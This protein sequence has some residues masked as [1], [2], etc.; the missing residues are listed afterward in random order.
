M[1]GGM[2]RIEPW[3][4]LFS[5]SSPVL[6]P[7]THGTLRMPF[8]FI[9]IYQNLGNSTSPFLLTAADGSTQFGGTHSCYRNSKGIKFLSNAI[10]WQLIVC[11]L[12]KSRELTGFHANL[13]Q[14]STILLTFVLTSIVFCRLFTVASL[15]KKKQKK[16]LHCRWQGN[17]NGYG[18]RKWSA[19][20]DKS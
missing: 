18:K 7:L 5:F 15:S 11:L 17:R 1:G 3:V 12:A 13:L 8:P 19:M 6:F 14:T 20:M 2:D 4:R 9:I 10:S 16:H